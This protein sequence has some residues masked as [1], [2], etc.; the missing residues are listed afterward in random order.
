MKVNVGGQK[1]RK[2]GPFKNWTIV[3]TR[4]GAEITM[5]IMRAS[6]PIP[7][8]KV[9]AL[10]TSHTLEHIFP[11]RLPFILTE[12]RR[13]LKPG[14]SLRVVVPDIDIAIRAYIRKDK[15]FLSDKRNPRKLAQLPALPLCFLSSWF[16]TYDYQAKGHARLTGGHVMAFNWEVLYHYLQDAGFKSIEKKSYNK[17]R[18]E[19]VQ[20]DFERYRDCSV[21]AEAIK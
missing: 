20:C 5:D 19:F 7:D 9:E 4:K 16:F 18:P 17:C 15:K 6:L 8:N 2:K 13:V 12:F 1:G 3:D 11:D 21:Y 10:Y 14:H